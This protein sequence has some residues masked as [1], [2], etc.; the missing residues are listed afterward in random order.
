[1]KHSVDSLIANSG[2]S[3][4]TQSWQPD[5]ETE[6]VMILAHGLTEH[7]GRYTPF[8]DY[9]VGRGFAV[10]ALDHEGHGRSEGRRGYIGHFSEFVDGLSQL[11]DQVAAKHPDH[12]RYLIGHSMGGVMSANYLLRDQSQLTGCVLSGPALVTDEVI[13]EFQKKL[14]KLLSLLVPKL[15]L[16]KL[17][18]GA[19]SRNPD[20]VEAYINDPL[21]FRG[22]GSARLIAE[23]LVAADYALEHAAEIQ[24]PILM[25]HGGDDKLANPKGSQ[26]LFDLVSSENKALK[27]YPDLYHE[28][29]LEDERDEVFSDINEWI[30]RQK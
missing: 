17:E 27:I 20:V 19:V 2:A 10:Y 7:S 15:P 30:G 9:F 11:V 23:L 13:S 29:F 4:Y 1:M 6:G 12:N 3:L 5:S 25:L 24:L 18:G 16:I 28:I 26:T 8:V 22:R 14:L 21:V